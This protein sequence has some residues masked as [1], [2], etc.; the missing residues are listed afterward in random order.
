MPV[1]AR[2]LFKNNSLTPFA[3]RS[4]EAKLASAARSD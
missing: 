4:N 3:G 2:N 1:K